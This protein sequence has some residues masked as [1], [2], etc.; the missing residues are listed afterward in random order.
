MML[1]LPIDHQRGNI[2]HHVANLL[3]EAA[4]DHSYAQHTETEALLWRALKV[5]G[6]L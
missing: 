5:E 1:S 2:W 3:N 6:L 4:A